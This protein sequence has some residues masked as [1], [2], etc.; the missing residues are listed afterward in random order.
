MPSKRELITPVLVRSG[1]ASLM[2]KTMPWDGVMTLNYHRIGDGSTSHF[3]R[4]LWSATEE[5]FDQQLKFVKSHYDIISPKDL[6]DV[7]IKAKGKFLIIT[8]DDGYLDN[9][10][11]AFPILKHNNMP[12]TFF[13][14]TGFIDNPSLPWWDEIAW[15]IRTSKKTQLDLQPWIQTPVPF[16]EPTR[17]RA[18]RTVLRAYKA[19]PTEKTPD[20]LNAIANAAGTGRCT[21]AETQNLWMNW[22]HLR[23]MHN[24]GMTIGGHTVNHPILARLPA[25]SQWNEISGCKK[26]LEAELKSPMTTFS[27]PVGHPD[28]FNADTR[29]CLRKAG[30]E[31]AFSYYAGIAL[32]SQWDHYDI[33]R[34]PID[35]DLSFDHFRAIVTLPNL[36]GRAEL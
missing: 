17:E 22:D 34:L 21:A 31:H 27:Y 15:M 30:V 23:E 5:Q 26:R 2:R 18:V 11:A 14:S 8:F 25:E 29:E 6:P 16:D 3:D 20:Y 35:N 7:R 24:A 19:M 36:F 4:G 28:A 32:F 13:I 9:Y 33:R 12:A 10:S 1:A